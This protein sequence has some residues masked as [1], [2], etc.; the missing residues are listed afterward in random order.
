MAWSEISKVQWDA[1]V[2]ACTNEAKTV[3]GPSV[4]CGC[5]SLSTIP[6]ERRVGDKS[7]VGF[8]PLQGEEVEAD[9]FYGNPSDPGDEMPVAELRETGVV[10]LQTGALM[11]NIMCYG[12]TADGVPD[13]PTVLGGV[14]SPNRT[15]PGFDA[16]VAQEIRKR[17]G[18]DVVVTVISQI[19]Q[20]STDS[21]DGTPRPVCLYTV[22][23]VIIRYAGGNIYLGDLHKGSPNDA[24]PTQLLPPN[25]S[26]RKLMNYSTAQVEVNKVIDSM[27][28]DL[29][30]APDVDDL[31]TEM[32]TGPED[33]EPYE[34]IILDPVDPP[35]LMPE[36]MFDGMGSDEFTMA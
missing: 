28:R 29:Y 36:D 30:A 6:K 20:V 12:N 4:D 34:V 7:D 31:R 24:T 35:P 27:M 5:G 23:E 18:E 15:Q 2:S 19:E 33:D 8:T 22:H 16:L 21:A 13:T 10:R 11:F 26:V 17:F 1:L 25:E 32:H 3:K 9:T 14:M